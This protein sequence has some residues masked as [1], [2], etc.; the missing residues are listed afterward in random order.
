LGA[1]INGLIFFKAVQQNDATTRQ[2]GF[3]LRPTPTPSFIVGFYPQLNLKKPFLS[4]PSLI[5]MSSTGLDDGRVGSRIENY[6]GF[7][8]KDTS[9]EAQ[10]DSDTR[11]EN[12]TDVVNGAVHSMLHTRLASLIHIPPYRLLRRRYRA[13]RVWLGPVIP[14]LAIL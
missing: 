3:S 11:V 4:L 12:Y 14:L 1:R 10:V 6:S 8:Q 9:K 7:W 2:T 5:V 13:L